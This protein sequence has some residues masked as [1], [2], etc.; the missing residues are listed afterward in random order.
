MGQF[1]DFAKVPGTQMSKFIILIVLVSGCITD[2]GKIDE[3]CDEIEEPCHWETE[4][5]DDDEAEDTG[6]SDS[7]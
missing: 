3:V 1:V 6:T 5:S 2:D 7:S 4:D